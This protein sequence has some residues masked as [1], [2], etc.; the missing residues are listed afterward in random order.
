[1][2]F[3]RNQGKLLT[4]NPAMLDQNY[5]EL[6]LKPNKRVTRQ[7]VMK[8]KDEFEEASKEMYDEEYDKLNLGQQFVAG[9]NAIQKQKWERRQKANQKIKAFVSK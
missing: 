1:M 7:P 5:G 6:R 2:K 8:L 3:F 9:Y 4:M